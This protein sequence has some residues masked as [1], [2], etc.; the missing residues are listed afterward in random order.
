[1]RTNTYFDEL[2]GNKVFRKRFKKEYAK[3]KEVEME[4]ADKQRLIVSLKQLSRALKSLNK[5][6]RA[7][8]KNHNIKIDSIIY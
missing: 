4:K 6:E 2:M 5:F 3:L 7:I 8:E 1:M